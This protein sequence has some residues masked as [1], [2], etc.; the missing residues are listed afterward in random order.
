MSTVLNFQS[1]LTRRTATPALDGAEECVVSPDD[2]HVYVAAY[3]KDAVISFSRTGSG[4]LNLVGVLQDVSQAGGTVKDLNA[5]RTI[6]MSPDGANVYVGCSNSDSIVCFNRDAGSGALAHNSAVING[7]GGVTG[8]NAV[9]AVIVSADGKWVL[10]SASSSDAVTIFSRG[11]DGSLTQ[12][13]SITEDVDGPYS[14]IL[15]P[16]NQHLYVSNSADDNILVYAFNTADGSVSHVQTLNNGAGGQGLDSV[17]GC[18]I[19]PDGK[20]LY[21]TGRNSDALSVYRID[22]DGTLTFVEVLVDTGR[23]G[24]TPN[25]NSPQNVL[26][27]G[28][29]QWVIVAS[30]LSDALVI[31]NRDAATGQLEMVQTFVDGDG[32]VNGLNG[33]AGMALAHSQKNLYVCGT[34]DDS[35]AVFAGPAI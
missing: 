26:V 12:A 33:A 28:D 23:G 22:G 20:N 17:R 32:G 5:P 25:L 27:S 21:A 9:R 1:V 2:K 16:T 15:S 7:E 14:L 8:L 3:A 6:A 18:A 4:D 19:S 35:I 34:S 11:A 30:N 31:F 13:G 10:A 29:G 24:S